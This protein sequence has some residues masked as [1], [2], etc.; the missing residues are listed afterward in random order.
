M[1]V[2]SSICIL[3]AHTLIGIQLHEYQV[4]G[5][6]SPT[7]D[8]PNPKIYRMRI[9][10][11]NQIVAVSRYWYFMRKLQKLKKANGEILAVNEVNFSFI[12][13]WQNVSSTPSFRVRFS[14]RSL[15][16]SRTLVSSSATIVGPALTICI[17]SSV[18][19]PG[20]VPS[21]SCVRIHVIALCYI[22]T[23]L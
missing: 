2:S 21:S 10:A 11:P 23:Y 3:D 4:V 13:F 22:S 12:V 17:R 9:F 5:R 7:K 1:T 19:L 14:R 15:S 6:R 16:R 8:Q 18:T 20:L